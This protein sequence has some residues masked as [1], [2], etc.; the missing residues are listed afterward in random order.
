MVFHICENEKS[1]RLKTQA[2]FNV[3]KVLDCE[4]LGDF[5][6]AQV[7]FIDG[8]ALNVTIY[9]LVSVRVYLFALLTPLDL[10]LFPCL[11]SFK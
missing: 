1:R 4:F 3:I 5:G 8:D 11:S 7:F 6:A 10:L 2:T 9:L